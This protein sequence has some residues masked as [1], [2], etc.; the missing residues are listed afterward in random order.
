MVEIVHD[1]ARQVKTPFYPCRRS[2][3]E[4]ARWGTV[5][6]VGISAEEVGSRV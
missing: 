1:R 6:R 3:T 2:R 5:P 4:L